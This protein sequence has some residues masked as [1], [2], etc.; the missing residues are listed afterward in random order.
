MHFVAALQPITRQHFGRCIFITSPERALGRTASQ[1][2]W[3]MYF[4]FLYIIFMMRS[5]V[6]FYDNSWLTGIVQ[7]VPAHFV[8][9][10]QV[11]LQ[12]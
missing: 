5:A 9:A 6:D 11:L 10:L 3:N 12:M 8:S 2:N 7:V 1:T 4:R